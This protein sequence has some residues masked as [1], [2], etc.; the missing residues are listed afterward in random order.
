MS[1]TVVMQ[2]PVGGTVAASQLRASDWLWRP[3]YAKLWWATIPFWWAG[4]TASM[5]VAPLA[6]FYESALAGYLNVVFFPLIALVALGVGW[7]RAFISGFA[8]EGGEKLP[9]E[10]L[11]ALN[12]A[13]EGYEEVLEDLIASTDPTD[14]RSDGLYFGNPLSFQ[15]PYR[16]F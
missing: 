8:L 9:V 15:Y 3:W 13:E 11:T 1:T 16:K 2:N 10:A 12:E 14:P 6:A 7:A 4:M 5:K